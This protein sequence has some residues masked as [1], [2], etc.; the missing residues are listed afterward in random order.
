MGKVNLSYWLQNY[1]QVYHEG[2]HVST[3]YKNY[4]SLIEINFLSY[5]LKRNKYIIA[6]LESVSGVSF[7]REQ[8]PQVQCAIIYIVV[9]IYYLR[10]LN[11]VL[12]FSF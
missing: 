9:L 11:I 7:E 12:A 5:V 10:N 4:E 2:L 1:L 6:F 8:S 3:M